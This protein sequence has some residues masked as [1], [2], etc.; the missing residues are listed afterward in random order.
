MPEYK[1]KIIG[2]QDECC[3]ENRKVTGSW[4]PEDGDPVLYVE[5]QVCGKKW[6]EVLD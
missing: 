1:G 6:A 4:F 3:E 2:K 5:C